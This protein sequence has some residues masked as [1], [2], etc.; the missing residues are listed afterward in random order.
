MMVESELVNTASRDSL[1][2]ISY[3]YMGLWIRMGAV[4]CIVMSS[5]KPCPWIKD[6]VSEST[7]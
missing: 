4:R 1:Q 5:F 3:I 6:R 7:G 2:A